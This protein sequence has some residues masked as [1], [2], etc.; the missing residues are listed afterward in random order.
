MY[1]AVSCC[2]ALYRTILHC[3]HCTVLYSNEVH[4]AV[5]NYA[6]LY[7]ALLLY[8]ILKYYTLFSTVMYST[9]CTALYLVKYTALH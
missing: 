6:V 2:T 3:N 8:A 1:Y 9:I 7:S 5:P 4:C